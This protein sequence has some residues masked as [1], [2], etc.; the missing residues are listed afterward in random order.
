MSRSSSDMAK[1]APS[2]AY[3]ELCVPSLSLRALLMTD[4]YLKDSAINFAHS[5]AVAMHQ[6]A[7]ASWRDRTSRAR[8]AEVTAETF[9]SRNLLARAFQGWQKRRK[10]E[11]HRFKNARLAR[12]WFIKRECWR[13]WLIAIDERALQQR[14]KYWK[15]TKTQNYFAGE[16][17]IPALP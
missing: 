14:L 5:K 13:R 6:R 1:Q 10:K 16:T 17:D 9:Y 15:R 2:Y 7:F 12:R 4:V 8:A 11:D 3:A